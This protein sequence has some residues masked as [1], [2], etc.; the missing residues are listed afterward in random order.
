MIPPR[1]LLCMA[2]GLLLISG[3]GPSERKQKVAAAQQAIEAETA[4]LA[5]LNEAVRQ[6]YA[7]A[8]VDQAEVR[9][10][11]KERGDELTKKYPPG[12]ELKAKVAELLK[13]EQ[14][15]VAKNNKRSADERSRIREEIRAQTERVK[16]ANEAHIAALSGK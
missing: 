4:K 12:D 8:D 2:L 5:E 7:R 6:T 15:M 16:A 9:A 11:V 1:G 14:Q 10:W 13:E 3:C